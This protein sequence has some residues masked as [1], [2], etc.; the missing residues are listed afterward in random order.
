MFSANLAASTAPS[1]SER[2]MFQST[3]SGTTRALDR[4]KETD[5]SPEAEI[6]R[7]YS[8]HPYVSRLASQ[9]AQSSVFKTGSDVDM[10]RLIWTLADA[11]SISLNLC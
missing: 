5:G 7:K 4:M 9:N 8:M 1:S 2:C 10:K 11:S 6:S 3:L